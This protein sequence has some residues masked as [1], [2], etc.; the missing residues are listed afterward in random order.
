MQALDGPVDWMT[1][2][3]RDILAGRPSELEAQVGAVV[4]LG[5]EAGVPTPMYSYMYGS[6]LLAEMKARGE[7]EFPD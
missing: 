3:H 4:R 1:S 6:L 2:M 7:I 5:E